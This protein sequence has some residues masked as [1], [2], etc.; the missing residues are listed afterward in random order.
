MP[1]RAALVARTRRLDADVDLIAVAGS[2]GVLIEQAGTGLAGRGEALRI[3]L[4]DG[5]G[6]LAVAAED[7]AGVLARVSV[8]DEVGLPGCGAVAFAALPFSEDT[9]GSVVVPS[10]VVGRADDGTRWVTTIGPKHHISSVVDMLAPRAIE[11]APT[12]F[13]VRPTRPP[14]EWCDTVAA[15]VARLRDRQL[16]KVVL[17]R[18]VVVE[19]D[20]PIDV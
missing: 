1:E 9:P 11:P 14:Q 5:R 3:A 13:D 16:A 7:V 19:A 15:V 2:D 18:E 20:A 12:A 10:L 8:D 6:R 17:A 4:P